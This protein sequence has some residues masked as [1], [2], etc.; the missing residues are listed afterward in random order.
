MS[1]HSHRTIYVGMHDGVCA[2]TSE[3]YGKNWLQGPVTTLPMPRR[4]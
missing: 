1:H 4:V 3:D 2:V